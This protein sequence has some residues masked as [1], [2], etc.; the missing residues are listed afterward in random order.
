[1]ENGCVL[2]YCAGEK[3]SFLK[4]RKVVLTRE[5]RIFVAKHYFRDQSYALCQETFQVALP[6]DTAPN[7]TAVYRIIT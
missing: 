1:V 5:Q 2:V 6:D 3:G 7:K 4:S